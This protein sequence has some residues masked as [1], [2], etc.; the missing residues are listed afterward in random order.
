MAGDG[1]VGAGVVGALLVGAELFHRSAND[2]LPLLVVS[3]G[4]DAVPL[5][6]GDP[7][8]G[9]PDSSGI[10]SRRGTEGTGVNSV[11]EADSVGTAATGSSGFA[12]KASAFNASTGLRPLRRVLRLSDSSLS[13]VDRSTVPGAVTTFGMRLPGE[14]G[15]GGMSVLGRM[16]AEAERPGMVGTESAGRRKLAVELGTGAGGS[17]RSL[18]EVPNRGTEG[19][20]AEVLGLAT[21]DPVAADEVRRLSISGASVSGSVAARLG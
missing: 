13:I 9:K 10:S 21:P 8:L 2:W 17:G 15:I 7:S 6:A 5:G 14:T 12:C 19:R 3:L 4:E 16:A 11:S 20:V 18:W 1:L